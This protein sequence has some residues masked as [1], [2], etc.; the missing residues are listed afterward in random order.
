MT[1]VTEAGWLSD[2]RVIAC[3]K[4]GGELPADVRDWVQD[5]RREHERVAEWGDGDAE[6]FW[7][8]FLADSVDALVV[9]ETSLRVHLATCFRNT[10]PYKAWTRSIVLTPEAS[11]SPEDRREIGNW[12]SGRIQDVRVAALIAREN[13]D[14]PTVREWMD[15]FNARAMSHCTR[16]GHPF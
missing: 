11:W 7:S 8:T 4:A 6:R 15:M 1:N 16:F 14:E 12:P 3:L 2:E 9:G 13:L 10:R 5:F